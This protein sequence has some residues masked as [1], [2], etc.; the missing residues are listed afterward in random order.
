MIW[1]TIVS[2]V[3]VNAI[4]S[5]IK[6]KKSILCSQICVILARILVSSQI[7]EFLLAKKCGRNFVDCLMY[8]L[9]VWYVI[10]RQ[11]LLVIIQELTL[12]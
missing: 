4:M 3:S 11:V 9:Y 1:N 6:R 2:S 5:D 8:S 12:R 10:D 7:Y